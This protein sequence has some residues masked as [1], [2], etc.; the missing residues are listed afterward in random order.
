ML[1]CGALLLKTLGAAAAVFWV[2]ANSKLRQ[3]GWLCGRLSWLEDCR[4]TMRLVRRRVGILG[5]GW[6]MGSDIIPLPKTCTYTSYIYIYTV[7]RR[8]MN[9][10]FQLIR[11]LALTTTRMSCALL[12]TSLQMARAWLEAK[13]LQVCFV[14]C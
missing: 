7:Y 9:K 5:E 10:Q 4:R 11:G 13:W 14:S 6:R 12:M 2:S 3:Q 8:Y 1:E